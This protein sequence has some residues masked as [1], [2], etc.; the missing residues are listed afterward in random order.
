M[1]TSTIPFDPG[2]GD[3]RL[4]TAEL[5]L[6]LGRLDDAR[7]ELEKLCASFPGV[8]KAYALQMGKEVRV[9]VENSR[10]SDQEARQANVGGEIL[11]TVF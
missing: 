9:L 11:C 1:T 8:E 6:R 2:Y 10:V 5:L 4:L 7:W 3:A